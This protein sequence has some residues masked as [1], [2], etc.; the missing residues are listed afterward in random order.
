MGR[1]RNQIAVVLLGKARDAL[2]DVRRGTD[3]AVDFNAASE[4]RFLIVET[5]TRRVNQVADIRRRHRR[6]QRGPVRRDL[7]ILNDVQ[8]SQLGTTL[9]REIRRR[10]KSAQRLIREISGQKNVAE[11]YLGPLWSVNPSCDLGK[12]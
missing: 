12:G 6:S 3:F 1:Q 11:L 9:T 2:G 7:H 4:Q 5:L 8:Q 10:R